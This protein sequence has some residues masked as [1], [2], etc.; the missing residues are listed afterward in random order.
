MKEEL[1]EWLDKRILQHKG[2]QNINDVIIVEGCQKVKRDLDTMGW[3]GAKE[4]LTKN[5]KMIYSNMVGPHRLGILIKDVSNK[6]WSL[7]HNK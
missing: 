3:E 1:I 7:E 2:S 4:Y 5:A 6:M